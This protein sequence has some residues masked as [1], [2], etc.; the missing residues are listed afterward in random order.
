L[1]FSDFTASVLNLVDTH[2]VMRVV[3]DLRNNEGGNTAVISP[4]I[5]GLMD[6]FS[7]GV[8]PSSAIAAAIIGRETFSLAVLNAITLKSL[9]I[10][11]AGETA[12]WN[13]SGFG[14]VQSFTLP[15]SRLNVNYSI[16]EFSPGVPGSTLNPDLPADLTWADYA[17]ERDA[18]LDAVL[19]LP[20][21]GGM[22]DGSQ[23]GL[24]KRR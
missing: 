6:R 19:A 16:R 4:L 10:P 9:G 21:S 22:A 13:P 15:N 14:E 17:V 2:T 7:R 20:L 8:I 5:A 11:P 24:H 3:I 18:F 23:S 1:K 12:G